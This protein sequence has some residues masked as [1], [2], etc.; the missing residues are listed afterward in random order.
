MQL[1]LLRHGRAADRLQWA[2]SDADRPLTVEGKRRCAELFPH[3]RRF[4]SVMTS[5]A[6]H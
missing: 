2:G 6:A 5:S 3:Y 1:V 4:I